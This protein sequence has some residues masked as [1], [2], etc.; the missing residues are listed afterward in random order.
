MDTKFWGPPGWKLL[1]LIT[2][3][4]H[5]SKHD[6]ECFFSTLP[7]VLPCKFCR[8]SLSEYVKEFPMK[9]A[10]DS[11]EPFAVA[12]WLWKIHNCVNSKLRD[13]KLLKEEDPPFSTVKK[14]YLA[15]FR[16]GCT[17][18]VFEGWEF[19][20]SIIE[21]HPFS[22]Q[23]MSGIPIKDAPDDIDPEDHLELNRWNKLPKEIR[24]KYLE[25]FWNCLPKVLPYPEWKSVWNSCEADWSSR[26][27]SMKSLWKIRCTLESSLQLLNRTNYHSLCKELRV[28]R[29]GCAKSERAKTCRRKKR[30]ATA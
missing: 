18:T 9:T 17:K 15:K 8:K 10:L 16:S 1:H 19:L 29:S 20:F 6:I 21:N 25:Q 24:Q 12:R 13:Q 28:H 27:S 23:S 11:N 3:A 14:I 5:T 30:A 26:E 22:K 2:F 4:Q 7:Y